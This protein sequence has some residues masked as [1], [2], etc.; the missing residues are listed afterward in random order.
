M[1]GGARRRGLRGRLLLTVLASVAVGVGL[2]TAAFNLVLH[3][4]L[5]A[6]AHSLLRARAAAQL[7]TL[8]T[9]NGRLAVGEAPDDA[10]ADAQVW[11]FSGSRAL[12]R[13]QRVA[14]VVDRA[15]TNLAAGPRRTADVA[16]PSTALLAVPVRRA[17][18][19]LGT[20]VVAVSRTPYE[21]TERVALI[22][23]LV[24]AG[25][26]LLAAGLVARWVLTAALR[27]VARMT[28]EAAEWSER[29]LDRR[30][31]LGPP[32]DELTGLAATL[33][34]LLDRLADAM[35]RE[36]RFS[37]ELSHELRTPLAKVSTQAQLLA[38]APDLP[39]ALRDDARAIV[40]AAAQMREAIEALL[41]A[42]RADSDEGHGS[43]DLVAAVR[44]AVEAARPLAAGRGIDIEGPGGASGF[45]VTAEPALVERM[46]A[47]LMDNA[48]R[49]ARTR[50]RVSVARGEAKAEVVVEDD[51]PGVAEGERRAIFEPGIRGEAGRDAHDGTGLGLAL[52]RRLAR[53]AGGEVE[54]GSRPEGGRFVVRLPLADPLSGRS[55]RSPAPTAR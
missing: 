21:R 37:A 10:G 28:A 39:A 15:A 5:N 16:T 12:E 29:D 41:A 50:V 33:D 8:E 52:A 46:L 25:L 2:L 17:G 27:P 36:Q 19:R 24:L 14:T 7:G 18:R 3:D 54:A 4:R 47:P 9:V 32:R 34:G 53:S 31:G 44:S 35:R 11:I 1:S 13:P 30:F 20:V 6:D 49:L 43:A 38:A 48:C 22:A 26:L 51:G 42:A 40:D 45:H 55:S 23:S